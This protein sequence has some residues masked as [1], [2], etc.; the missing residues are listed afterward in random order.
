M[1]S[2]LYNHLIAKPHPSD[3]SIIWSKKLRKL[4]D[5]GPKESKSS[6]CIVIWVLMAHLV[7][8]EVAKSQ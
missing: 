3:H 8:L 4:C 1:T 6:L 7:I 5:Q 2:N